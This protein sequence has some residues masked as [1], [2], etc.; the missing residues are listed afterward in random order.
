MDYSQF[1]ED[2]IAS[3]QKTV[4][5]AKAINALSG[6]VDSST[7]TVLGH[8]AIGQQLK[9]VF[10]DNALMREGEPQRVVKLF[11]DMGIPVDIVDARQEFLSSVQIAFRSSRFLYWAKLTAD[12]RHFQCRNR[13]ALISCDVGRHD[14]RQTFHKN[15]TVER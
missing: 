11:A 13:M 7:V 14:Q 12:F 6:G 15:R 10:V 3:I 4:G 1:V 9:T 2:Q 5:S 8:R